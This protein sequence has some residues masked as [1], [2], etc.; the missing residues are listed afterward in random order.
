MCAH[1]NVI[2]QKKNRIRWETKIQPSDFYGESTNTYLTLTWVVDCLSEGE[3]KRSWKQAKIICHYL[4]CSRVET[5]TENS[6]PFGVYKK[7]NLVKTFQVLEE[8]SRLELSSLQLSLLS[9][10]FY[11]SSP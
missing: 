10:P 5:G 8:L 3:G 6:T 1:K 4:A 9:L 11:C 7:Q 2:I